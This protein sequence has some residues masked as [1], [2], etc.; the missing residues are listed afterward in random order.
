MFLTT[1]ETHNLGYGSLM[2]L[3]VPL[4]LFTRIL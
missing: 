2:L 3:Q 1:S 4:Q